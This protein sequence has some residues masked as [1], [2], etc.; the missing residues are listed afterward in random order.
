MPRWE[1]LLVTPPIRSQSVYLMFLLQQMRV[2]IRN[3]AMRRPLPLLQRLPA[4]EQALGRWRLPILQDYRA[5]L[6]IQMIPHTTFTGAEPGVYIFQWEVSNAECSGSDLVRIDNYPEPT[7]ANAG[8][9]FDNCGFTAQLNGNTATSGLGEW[10]V[11][12]TPM[13]AP[14][15]NIQNP[16]LPNTQVTNLI[17]G[18]YTFR[19]TISSGPICTPTQDDVVVTVIENPTQAVANDIEVCPEIVPEFFSLDGNT[20]TV[21]NGTWTVESQPMGSGPVDLWIPRI[22]RQM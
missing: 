4:L 12:S 1:E 3:C 9:D 5:L 18:D 7:V 8:A 20:P 21:G 22:R 19:W 11:I 15:P 16:I 13:G 14:T 10:T 17:V 6:L 2:R